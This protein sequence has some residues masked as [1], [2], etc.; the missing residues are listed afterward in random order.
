MG[1][2]YDYFRAPGD[3]AVRRRLDENDAMSPL[4]DPF[5]G[6]A[7]KTIDPTVIL[8]QLIAAALGRGW[9]VD[10]MKDRLIWPEGGEQD[11]GHE[12]PW[13]TRLSDQARDALA[14]IPADRV[15][16]LAEQWAT[17]EEFHGYG[18]PE[19]LR[20]VITDFIALT[21]QAGERNEAVYCWIC[22]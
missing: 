21:M 16:A 6:I 19:Y 22:L 17:A 10:L 2:L 1:I 14:G 12:G 7:L 5:P 11:P 15:P 8:G 13:V 4:D 9:D 18:D 3:D 20:E